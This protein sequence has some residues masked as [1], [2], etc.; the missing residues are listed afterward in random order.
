VWSFFIQI[1]C[2]LYHIHR[3]RVLHRDLKSLN[4]F[5][6]KSDRVKLGDFGVAKVLGNTK[7]FAMTLVGT[8][9]YLSPEL[10]E[11]K[12]YNEKSDVWALGCI[13]YELCT[14]KHR[15]DAMN[16]GA[17]ILK[18]VRGKYPQVSS[19]YSQE[20]RNLVDRC[21]SLQKST[22]TLKG[23]QS[24]VRVSL[25]ILMNEPPLHTPYM[26]Q[27]SCTINFRATNR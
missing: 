25:L 7:S 26:T 23:T 4:I 18:I 6:D 10:C 16:Q 9:Y 22:S 24:P 19:F 5:L 17:L 2:G 14:M 15:F 8:P 13:L 3:K 1:A 12:P 20:L 21:V 11:N 27:L